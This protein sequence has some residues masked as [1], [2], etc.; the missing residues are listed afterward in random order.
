[1][2]ITQQAN[3][4]TVIGNGAPNQAREGVQRRSDDEDGGTGATGAVLG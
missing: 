1:M 3:Q 2:T 4:K